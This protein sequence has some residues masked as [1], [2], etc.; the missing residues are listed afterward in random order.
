MRGV[1]GWE[2]GE[3][4]PRGPRLARG[5]RI[6]PWPDAGFKRGDEEEGRGGRRG[7]TTCCPAHPSRACPITGLEAYCI[8]YLTMLGP[9]HWA[10]LGQRRV[11]LFLWPY[12]K[13]QNWKRQPTHT[14]PTL[15]SDTP[16]SLPSPPLASSLTPL[17]HPGPV[18]P[19]APPLVMPP[20]PP[21]TSSSHLPPVKLGK[22]LAAP[23]PAPPLSPCIWGERSPHE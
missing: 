2:E 17:C 16:P 6:R 20:V 12:R 13:P 22:P 4:R 10:P 1:K 21:W 9:R 3:C 14:C 8:P 18:L 23:C 7:G 19:L 11:I 5:S 15:P